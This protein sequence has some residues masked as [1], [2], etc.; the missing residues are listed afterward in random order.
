LPGGN[1]IKS[2]EQGVKSKGKKRIKW[3]GSKEES[4]Y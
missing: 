3:T 4:V 1:R 2:K